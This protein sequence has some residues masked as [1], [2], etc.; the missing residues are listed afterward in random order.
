MKA[1]V[2]THNILVKLMILPRSTLSGTYLRLWT[3]SRTRFI[4]R[5]MLSPFSVPAIT[6]PQQGSILDSDYTYTWILTIP[7]RWIKYT[8]LQ[9]VFSLKHVVVFGW[10]KISSKMAV[11]PYRGLFWLDLTWLLYWYLRNCAVHL[12]P[13]ILLTQIGVLT[14]FETK[15]LLWD[16]TAKS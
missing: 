8:A 3:H 10:G 6:F 13:L 12:R 4:H 1:N 9:V 2:H 5:T 14:L 15:E 11:I 16:C 7:L